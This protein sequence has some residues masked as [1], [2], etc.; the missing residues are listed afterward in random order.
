MFT[1]CTIIVLHVIKCRN[2]SHIIQLKCESG[3]F[4]LIPE[5]LSQSIK[6]RDIAAIR[7]AKLFFRS[8]LCVGKSCLWE[9]VF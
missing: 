4:V 5:L 9:N 3:H 2:Y 1:L 8:C 6:R 7:K